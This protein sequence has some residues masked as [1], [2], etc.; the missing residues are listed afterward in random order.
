LIC[1]YRPEW[2][3][4]R[5]YAPN[6]GVGGVNSLAFTL[7]YPAYG[8]TASVFI[9]CGDSGAIGL[10]VQQVAYNTCSYPLYTG[11]T[12]D[13][14]PGYVRS[15]GG[16]YPIPPPPYGRVPDFVYGTPTTY[17]WQVA[18][19]NGCNAG[20]Q[21]QTVNYDGANTITFYTGTLAPL[22]NV[23]VTWDSAG[24]PVINIPPEPPPCDPN[25]LYGGCYECTINCGGDSGDSFL[26]GTKILTSTQE[27]KPIETI[28]VGDSVIGSDE[29]VNKVIGLYR[30]KLGSRGLYE[31]NGEVATTRDHLFRMASGKW[32]ALSPRDYEILR[33]GK[34]MGITVGGGQIK[35]RISSKILSSNVARISEGSWLELFD[36]TIKMVSSITLLS[37]YGPDT[38]LY[39]LVTDGN[40]SFTVQGGYVAD[41]MPQK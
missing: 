40:E 3:N 22:G 24:T 41:G 23:T 31:I 7:G 13:S 16:C 11:P 36:G 18:S 29:K 20:C 26:A 14:S 33:F 1:L 5:A 10:K 25:D 28:V 9:Q 4:F 32:G 17:T 35:E 34:V 21:M 38:V 6:V 19:G 27:W 8:P 39:T 2:S 30:P 12:F 15:D 37:G